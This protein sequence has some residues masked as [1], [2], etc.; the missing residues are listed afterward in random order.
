MMAK[1]PVHWLKEI[2]L[3]KNLKVESKV[4]KNLKVRSRLMKKNKANQVMNLN[5]VNAML[6]NN[7]QDL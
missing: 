6:A 1:M 2:R 5:S 3:M 4:I 7:H